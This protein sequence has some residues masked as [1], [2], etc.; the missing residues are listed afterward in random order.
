M[1]TLPRDNGLKNTV[2]TTFLHTARNLAQ[3]SVGDDVVSINT[4]GHTTVIL[5]SAAAVTD[6]LVTRGA[7]Y[8]DRPSLPMI[9]DLC[10]FFLSLFPTR[11]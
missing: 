11:I 9:V 4:F 8:S 5:N 6:L 3:L 2:S 10:V 7:N 1:C